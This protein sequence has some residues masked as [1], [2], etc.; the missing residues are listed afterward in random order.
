MK[1]FFN[2]LRFKI[3]IIVAAI[4][5][6]FMVLAISNDTVATVVEQGLD[7]IIT[8][9]K[10]VSASI[11]NSVGEFFSRY[12]NSSALYDEN[13]RLKAQI[14]ELNRKLADYDSMLLENENL[15][16][17]L[18]IKEANPSLELEP[19]LVI[20]MDTNEKFG[21]FTINRGYIH[22][23][24]PNDPVI[25]DEGLVG[26]VSQVNAISSRVITILDMSLKVGAY[27][28]STNDVGIIKN[29]IDYSIDGYTRLTMLPRSTASKEGDLVL[30]S[31]S[32]ELFP[33]DIIIGKISYLELDENGLSM[34][35]VV[36]PAVD[37]QNVKDVAVIKSF[38]SQTVL[39][40][41]DVSSE[42]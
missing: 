13:E 11:S 24:E 3:L 22:G 23:V 36:S 18:N 14:N 42:G 10:S 17:F 37:L 31:G 1:E 34:V 5:A 12:T 35:A 20:G 8:P 19:A 9:I 29:D 33:S 6:V 30:T 27:V 21:S 16:N 41:E 2:S 40:S 15:K 26:V 7:F 28:S 39:P 4:L 32:S 38:S 25:T